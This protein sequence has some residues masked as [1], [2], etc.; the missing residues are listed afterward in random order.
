MTPTESRQILR[1]AVPAFGALVAEP[2]YVLYD[3]A[4]VGR[5]GAQSLAGMAI[6]GLILAQVGAQLT[7]LAYGTT[8]RS[9]RLYGSG[10][11]RGA[12]GEGV[13]STWLALGIGMAIVVAMQALA[14]PVAEIIGG[15]DIASIAV[16]WLRIALFGV[17]LILVA[18]AGSGWLRGVSDTARPLGYVAAGLV[19]SALLCPA[20]VHGW[21]ILPHLGVPGSAVAN[22]AGQSVTAVLFLRALLAERVVLRPD[23]AVMR[24][25]L[26]L[27]RDL[28]ARSL[29]F[30]VCFLSAGAVAARFGA[31]AVGAH[32]VVLQLWNLIALLLDSIA[33]AAQALVGAALGSGRVD[34]AKAL[35][36]RLTRWSA[37]MALVVAAVVAALYGLLPPLLA[38]DATV[39]SRAH[40][41]W[42]ILV[43][44]IPLGGIVFALDGV[45][46]GAGDAAF[47]RN[48]T[49]ASALVGFLPLIW[50]SFAFD[51][52]LRGIWAGLGAF[53]T[54]RVLAVVWRTSS[55]KWAI[56]GARVPQV[57][58]GAILD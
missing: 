24:D 21:L 27:G 12:A 34:E 3:L 14:Q 56:A 7:F 54:L 17:P 45:L 1:L 55:G 10:S 18:L 2:L 6:G 32:Q 5:L 30:Q 38:P 43:A 31:A 9:A 28:I 22:V 13:Q 48:I 51:W 58:K 23:F 26:R 16:E 41:V 29:G 33:I 46:L 19:V 53:I 47:L 20:L 57:E 8:A 35:A 39:V 44:L 36:W 42:W 49:L 15:P 4:V 37:V 52:G 25:Q 11:R 40:E 50:L